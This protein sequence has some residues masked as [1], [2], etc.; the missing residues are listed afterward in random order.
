MAGSVV[1]AFCSRQV[2]AEAGIGRYVSPVGKTKALLLVRS[3]F[4]R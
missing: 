4:G 3:A 1:G 2:R